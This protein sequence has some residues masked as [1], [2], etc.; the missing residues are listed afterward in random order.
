[1]GSD[2]VYTAIVLQGGGSLGAYEY[3]VLKALYEQRPGFTPVAVAGI[4]IGAINAAVL[5]GAKTD[6]IGALDMLWRDRLTV[7]TPL[8]PWLPNWLDS[9][10]ALMGNPG[11]YSINPE[12]FVS[13][14]TSTSLYD[15]APL[16]RTL[17]D[18]VDLD[19][20]NDNHTQVI[21]G[22]INIG[23][24]EI[25]YFDRDQPGR[26]KLD[27]VVASGSLPPMF[28]MTN[29]RANGR[30]EW[31]WDGGLFAN[32]PLGPAINA[33]ERAAGGDRDAV[34]ELIVV[35]LFPMKGTVPSN[36]RQVRERSRQ[37]QYTSRM[38]LDTKFF[39]KIN[40]I[41]DLMSQIDNV[42]GS[43]AIQNDPVYAQLR[44]HR[45]INYY[46][47]VTAALSPESSDSGDFSKS[48]IESRIRVGYEDALRQGIGRVNSAGLR[49]G[50]LRTP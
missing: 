30:H 11:M 25:E 31:Y 36:L 34:R 1:M 2:T 15:T 6:P 39:E 10:S 43:H 33:L 18:L 40:G 23:T 13:P 3:G 27:H 20:L 44:A 19:T 42:I 47:V 45:K 32:T 46:N 8:S 5:G 14:W 28:P 24:G 29:A 16:R 26:L 7:A 37:F 49:P 35:E 4:S 41:V 48:A 50:L 9:F 12:L 17:E 22:A 38:S 21:V